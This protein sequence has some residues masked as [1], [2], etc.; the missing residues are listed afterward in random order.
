MGPVELWDQIE[1]ISMEQQD[2][3]ALRLANGFY[4]ERTG[5]PNVFAEAISCYIDCEHTGTWESTKDGSMIWRQ[6]VRS[7]GAH[8][9]NLAFTEFFLPS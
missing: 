8:S 6:R 4:E 5:G 7:N 9:I 1:V 2:N 3:E